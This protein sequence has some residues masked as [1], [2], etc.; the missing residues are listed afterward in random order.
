MFC[1]NAKLKT[2]FLSRGKSF[3]TLLIISIIN[4]L[5]I[6][7]KTKQQD[8]YNDLMSRRMVTYKTFHTDQV[9]K[10]LK[11]INRYFISIPHNLWGSS[12]EQTNSCYSNTLFLCHIFV[13][14][15][16]RY[17]FLAIHVS[18]FLQFIFYYW[19]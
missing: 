6:K 19:L 3:I 2:R 10:K 14:V 13:S 17:L 12:K 11:V 16:I 9:K 15:C 1:N 7:T 8:S 18:Y 5:D 4:L